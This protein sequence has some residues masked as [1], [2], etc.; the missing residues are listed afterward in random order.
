MIFKGKAHPLLPPVINKH[1]KSPSIPVMRF[2]ENGF[3]DRPGTRSLMPVKSDFTLPKISRPS[4]IK[5]TQVDNFLT[6]EPS[7][8]S[9]LLTL[10]NLKT[11]NFN[12]PLQ[13]LSEGKR[14]CTSFFA[15]RHT[16]GS[17]I[18]NHKHKDSQLT[19]LSE[20]SFGLIHD[21]ENSIPCFKIS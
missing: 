6:Q 8:N 2:K 21:D 15:L 17:K 11:P 9:N 1:R 14:N 13:Q 19:N 5:D 20:I 10:K 7:L 12:G 4:V 16:N 18:S 3:S